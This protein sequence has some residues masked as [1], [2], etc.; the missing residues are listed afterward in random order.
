MAAHKFSRLLLLLKEV[1]TNPWQTVNSLCKTLGIGRAQFYRDKQALKEIEFIFDYSRSE[2]RFLITKDAY[3]PI[4]KLTLSE[5]FALTMAVRQLSAAGDFILTYDAI[6]AIRKIVTNAPTAQ[7]ELLVSC[8]DDTVL[9]AGFGCKPHVLEE[10]RKAVLEERRIKIHYTPP[11]AD[12][13]KAYTLDPYQ[14]YFKRRALY[15]DAYD[16]EDKV[17][18]VFRVNR[19]S[20]V[21]PTGMI[22]PRRADYN[23]AQR[24]RHAFSVFVGGAVQRVRVRFAK[25]IAPFIREVCWHHSQQLTEEPDGNLLFEVAVNEPR[26][27]GWWVLQWGAEAE[28]LEPESLRQELHQTAQRLA[29][30]YKGRENNQRIEK[31]KEQ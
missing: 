26:E 29:I 2:G 11:A 20:E 12:T 24:H 4:Y 5:T 8:L 16:T 31:G 21:Q 30:L 23:F 18:K 6:E 13:A 7:R 17:Y 10:L 1:K 22:V 9:Q 14:I 19:I 25:R 3:I 28:V 27:V 15:L